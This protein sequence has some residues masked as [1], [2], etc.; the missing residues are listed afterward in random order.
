MPLEKTTQLTQSLKGSFVAEAVCD[1]GCTP[2]DFDSVIVTIMLPGSTEWYA[3]RDLVSR[4]LIEVKISGIGD[5]DD[6]AGLAEINW[7]NWDTFELFIY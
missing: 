3:E 7:L 6:I 4:S 1:H 2:G 5:A